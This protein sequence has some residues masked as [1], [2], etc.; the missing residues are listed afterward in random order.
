VTT[1][2]FGASSSFPATVSQLRWARIRAAALATIPLVLF[3]VAALPRI[4]APD[5][6]PFG[7]RQAAYVLEARSRAPVSP[8][9]WYADPT[10]PTLALV[11][12]FLSVLPSPIAAWVV[13]RGLLD[14][15][16]VAL[17]Y[18]A[19]RRVVG[20]TGGVM[21]ALLY[22]LSPTAWAASRDPAGP[23][24]APV[25]AAA[26]LAAILLAARPTL[27][28]AAI[29]GVLLG[30]LARG[31][32]AGLVV[33]LI[34]AATLAVG[35]ASWKV[36]GMTALG[37]VLAAGPAL[38]AIQSGSA[39]RPISALDIVRAPGW[40]ISGV[41]Y[42][43]FD[44]YAPGAVLLL[45]FDW[46]IAGL[47]LLAMAL[48]VVSRLANGHRR[49]D[50]APVLLMTVLLFVTVCAAFPSGEPGRSGPR[51]GTSLLLT[52]GTLVVVLPGLAVTL[53]LLLTARISG[54]FAVV[55]WLA[56]IPVLLL[57]AVGAL[58]LG[59]T[60]MGIEQHPQ[61]LPDPRQR[62]RTD[63]VVGD[64]VQD[65]G[66]VVGAATSLRQWTAMANAVR[67]VTRRLESHEIVAAS[68]S[69]SDPDHPIAV[70]L[71]DEIAVRYMAGAIVLPLAQEIAYVLLPGLDPSDHLVSPSSAQAI[72]TSSG[73]DTGARIVTIR[74]RTATDW[75]SRVQ[76][77]PDGRFADGSTLLGIDHVSRRDE[78]PVP[79]LSFRLY[80]RL[81][82]APEG[83]NV[84][85]QVVLESPW[86]ATLATRS[87]MLPP[88]SHRRETEIVVKE[89][90]LTTRGQEQ[91]SVIEIGLRDSSG[92]V[93]PTAS[94]A[95]SLR[96]TLRGVQE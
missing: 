14:A 79:V 78:A 8:A 43:P 52:G 53:A 59:R 37:L 13:V 85:D 60:L 66:G 51:D 89:Y 9:T 71:G 29:F 32:P 23:L 28:R 7:D 19:A 57:L 49:R 34:G 74:P 35:R 50:A 72:F 88:R 73:G 10:V 96:V 40:L 15:L 62:H 91:G 86:R 55:R 12:P 3:L 77:I 83:T 47:A 63:V 94:G 6:V 26:L 54:R 75:L 48:A 18:L 24:G 61:T 36:G 67:E 93:I 38:F 46:W 84:A 56:P 42:A 87:G 80:W 70:L 11:E 65:L 4:W 33:V 31:V 45:D 27:L 44:G 39:F 69:V 1:D 58:T 21:A 82:G 76:A 41:A 17:L 16:G 2:P 25:A 20:V 5:L 81:R 22:A 92:A 68:G 95:P 30:L 90:T 64:P